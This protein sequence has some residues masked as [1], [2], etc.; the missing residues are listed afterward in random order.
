MYIVKYLQ[1]NVMMK[2]LCWKIQLYQI[3]RKEVC[4]INFIHLL[5]SLEVGFLRMRLGFLEHD[6]N[7]EYWTI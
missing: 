1:I 4:I 6:V 3:L 5:Q 7:L 2:L